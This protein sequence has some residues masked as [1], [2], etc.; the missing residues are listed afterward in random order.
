MRFGGRSGAGNGRRCR[1]NR[2]A[3]GIA[4]PG[5]GAAGRR[6]LRLRRLPPSRQVRPVQINIA[7][8]TAR[9]NR[10]VGVDIQATIT[11]WQREFDRLESELQKQRLRYSELNNL[12]DESSASAPR[13]RNSGASSSRRSRP[14]RPRWIC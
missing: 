9:A 8:I 11:G 4:N 13:S 7:E 1:P 3:T 5:S 12:R 2:T 10:D 6:S 14:Q